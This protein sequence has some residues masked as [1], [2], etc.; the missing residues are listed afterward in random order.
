MR[1]QVLAAGLLV[2]YGTALPAQ[3]HAHPHWSYE[4]ATAPNHWAELET[5]Y[6]PC[7]LGKEQSPID[8]R[9]TKKAA[10]AP[11]AF[12][13]TEGPAEIVNNGHTVQVTPS[14]GGSI[15]VGASEYK[16]VQFHFHTPSEEKTQGKAHAMVAHFVH[17]NT[18][19]NLAVVA[20]LL[21]GG[22]GNAAWKA[23]LDSL[24]GKEGETR[25]LTGVDPARLLPRG[26]GYYMFNGSLTTPPC[27]E[28]VRWF[29]LKEPV[30]IAPE[31]IAAFQ[32]LYSHN[33]RPVQPLNGRTV[34]ESQ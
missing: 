21:D 31:A 20:V 14:A 9:E 12:A 26:L 32:K 34:Q 33:A 2:A 13:Y 6:A 18:E 25:A 28:G 5:D 23:I 11:I 15:R 8:I 16:L 29:V 24:P 7:K 10:L 17:K 22:K 4:G 3:E 30:T 1:L 27:S 19:G